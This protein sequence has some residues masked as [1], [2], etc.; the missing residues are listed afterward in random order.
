MRLNG[1][2]KDGE[3]DEFVKEI[4]YSELHKN[5]RVVKNVVQILITAVKL[6]S[7]LIS[8]VASVILKMSLVL[9]ET[10]QKLFKSFLS[11]LMFQDFSQLQGSAELIELLRQLFDAKYLVRME[12]LEE[13]Q[14]LSFYIGREKTAL[15]VIFLFV[16][17]FEDEFELRKL[18]NNEQ[19][20]LFRIGE[21]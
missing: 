21:I 3:A 2:L 16:K 14:K 7:R 9:D 1:K 11:H 18:S 10:M 8:K 12:I 19:T 15:Q 5:S 13:L 17:T 4:Q 20:M 6:D